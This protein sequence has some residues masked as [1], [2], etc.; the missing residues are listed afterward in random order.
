MPRREIQMLFALEA[1]SRQIE[2]NQ[3]RRSSAVATVR[4]LPDRRTF[5]ASTER[6]GYSKDKAR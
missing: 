4:Q 2:M 3:V 6:R 1:R 5:F